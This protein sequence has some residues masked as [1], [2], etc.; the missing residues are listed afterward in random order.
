MERRST[1]YKCAA[2]DYNKKT[3]HSKTQLVGHFNRF[4]C[5]KRTGNLSTKPDTAV[6]HY[7]DDSD[8]LDLSGPEPEPESLFREDPKKARERRLKRMEQQK[9]L[10]E[11][12]FNCVVFQNK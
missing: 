8:S 3:E 6:F 2:G 1:S 7:D 5:N 4:L 12:Y 10:G 11:I 9:P